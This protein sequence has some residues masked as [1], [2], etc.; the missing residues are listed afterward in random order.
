MNVSNS[1]ATSCGPLSLTSC[2]GRSKRLKIDL[3]ASTVSLPRFSSSQLL[4]AICYEHRPSLRTCDS[5]VVPQ[6]R[7]ELF[8]KVLLA[9]PMGVVVLAL[10]GVSF[11]A[12][13]GRT[14]LFPQYQHPGQATRNSCVQF[15]SFAP[16]HSVQRAILQAP[17]F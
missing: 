11:S 12:S 14:L 6:S 13:Q 16:L 2:C 3:S 1:S 7:C 9:S 5:P 8:A 17:S 4:L 10:G 15:L